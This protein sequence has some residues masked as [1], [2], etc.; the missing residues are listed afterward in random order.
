MMESASTYP[1]RVFGLQVPE[2]VVRYLPWVSI[3][4][5][6][7]MYGVGLVG[8]QT[9]A[10][11]WF[12]DATPLTL[13]LSS[14]LLLLNHRGWSA[15]FAGLVG[16]IAVAG[17]LVEV[18]GVQTGLIFGEYAYGQV[19]GPKLWETPLVIGLNWLL[20]VYATG[21]LASRLQLPRLLQAGVAA[22]G[23]TLLDVLIEPVA[24]RLGFWD[25]SWGMVP[26][27]NYLAWFFASF[28]LL[29]VFVHFWQHR[30]N[31]LA[32]AVLVLQVIFFGTLNLNI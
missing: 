6:V 30:P 31:P 16:G 22:L 23:M 11:D 27:Q 14:G 12:L 1:R 20:L 32:L 24:M 4:I 2:W 28:C 9:A 3:G 29:L 13:V 21:S 18:A 10:R 15:A 5:L 19:L 25:W 17:F 7:V 8:L 26:L